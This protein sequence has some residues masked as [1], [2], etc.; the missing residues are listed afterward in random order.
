MQKSRGGS[1]PKPRYQVE[2]G[3]EKLEP[4][5]LVENGETSAVGGSPAEGNW[6]TRRVQD[7]P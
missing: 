4:L 3:N 5:A 1:P 6:R 2:P 7:V